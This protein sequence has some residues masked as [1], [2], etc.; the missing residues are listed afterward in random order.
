MKGERARVSTNFHEFRMGSIA[1]KTLYRSSHPI[2]D[3]DIKD[4]KA[5]AKYATKA[6]IAA[7]LNLNNTKAELK[8][9]AVFA[10]WYH[11]LY[12][13][14]CIIA[15]DMN[16]DYLS[17]R[18]CTKFR[19]G[20]QFMLTQSGPY[21]VHCYAGV[22]RTGFVCAVLGS[23]MGA[24]LREIVA[25]YVASYNDST[26]TRNEYKEYSQIIVDLFREMNGGG[27]ISD[28]NLQSVAEDFL[29]HKVKLTRK[30]LAGLKMILSINRK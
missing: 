30:E 4:A 5:I 14:D 24:K 28:K 27:K 29:L 17:S 11:D 19:R 20:I 22:D 26:M 18:F 2:T 13:A 9:L 6:K 10:P 3:A 7:V 1:P 21:L 15:L 12:K 25:D 23:L 8:A 16:F